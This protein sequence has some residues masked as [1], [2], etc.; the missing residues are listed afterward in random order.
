[1]KLKTTRK[2]EILVMVTDD[3]YFPGLKASRSMFQSHVLGICGEHNGGIYR[4]HVLFLEFHL[5]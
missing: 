2:Y 5:P 1:M 3:D 4:K